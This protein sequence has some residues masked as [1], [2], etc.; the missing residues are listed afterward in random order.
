[1]VDHATA[2]YL[3]DNV[4]TVLAKALADMAVQQ[5]AD[6]V[7]FLAKWLKQYA[8]REEDKQ[9]QEVE[10]K[11]LEEDRA[12]AKA[13][14]DAKEAEAKTR[15]A[16]ADAKTAKYQGLM[17]KFSN[18]DTTFEDACWGELV[19]VAQTVTGASAVYLGLLEEDGLQGEAPGPCIAYTS[20]SA[21]SEWMVDTVLPDQTG[22][23]WG[24]LKQPVEEEDFAK[25]SLW[26][27]PMPPAPDPADAPEPAEGEEPPAEDAEGG[28]PARPTLPYYPVNVPCVTD[29]DQMHYFDLTRL[30]AY[31]AVPLVYPTYYTADSLADA[32]TFETEKKAADAEREEARLKK[33]EELEALKAQAEADGTEP[34]DEETFLAEEPAPEK[35]MVLRGK[36]IK[37]VLCLDTLGTNTAIDEAK[38]PEML[39]LCKACALCKSQTE[40]KWVDKQ[41]LVEID[42]DMRTAAEESVSNYRKEADEALVT[43][44][45]EEEAA[46]EEE[47]K[48]ECI[49]EKYAYLRAKMVMQS[50]KQEILELTSW[51]VAPPELM[52]LVANFALMF[53]YTKEQVYPKKK[54][55]LSWAKLSTVLSAALLEACEGCDVTL[56]RR[57]LAPEQK[58]NS[59]RDQ[60]LALDEE[61]AQALWPTVAPLAAVLR[62]A[63]SYRAAHLKLRKADFEREKAAK[64]AEGEEF[65]AQP[66]EEVDDDF[67]E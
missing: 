36:D 19:S 42:P 54:T 62:Q 29:V 66:L 25:Y 5:P 56:E 60:G 28:A 50:M 30:G 63:V 26:R 43:E 64:E 44:Q 2:K 23:T 1:M 22:V 41:A 21:G 55:V 40:T 3:S 38:I 7:D 48:K 53:G 59:I 6:G 11:K 17:D 37:M 31:L 45:Q 9:K 34:P 14:L 8:E 67:V 61:K 35:P 10:K 39:E 49:K 52:A 33:V 15:Q 65:K 46:A 27:P 18:A 58:L 13:A 20:A 24:A 57:G 4:G 12:K 16:A 47:E 32:K 51:V